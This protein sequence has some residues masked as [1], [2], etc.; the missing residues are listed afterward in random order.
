M[1][2]AEGL[3]SYLVAALSR[4]AASTYPRTS[5]GKLGGLGWVMRD[6]GQSNRIKVN[7]SDPSDF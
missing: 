5:P 1:K 6:Q 7:Q 2:L 3:A 4:T